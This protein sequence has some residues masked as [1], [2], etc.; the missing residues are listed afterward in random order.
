MPNLSRITIAVVSDPHFCNAKLEGEGSEASHIVIERL[1]ESFGKNPWK[2]L[3]TLV[4]DNNISADFLL[5]PGDITTHAQTKPLEIAWDGLVEL[6]KAMKVS[7]LA[8]ATGNHDVRSRIEEKNTTTIKDLDL[9]HQLFENLKLLSPAYPL[10]L[11]TEK[12]DDSLHRSIRI[13]YF[14]ADFVIHQNEAV[15]LVVFNSC[16]RHITDSDSYERGIIAK[17]TLHELK[18]QLAETSSK[19]INIFLCH[20]HP[21]LHSQDG[22]G[23]YDFMHGGDDLLKILEED[24]DWIVIH[25]HKHEGRLIY[26]PGSTASPVVFSAAS[27]GAVLSSHSLDKYR[28]QFYLLDIE[29]PQLAGPRGVL[30]AWDWHLST[31]WEEAVTGQQGLRSGMGFGE[32]RHPNVLASEIASVVGSSLKKWND[33]ISACPFIRNLTPETLAAVIKALDKQHNLKTTPDPISKTIDQIGPRAN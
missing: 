33:V 21:C 3:L 11:Y 17:S 23:S 28:N 6:G 20:H 13:H 32:R 22:Q 27:I 7:L 10:Q 9:P 19:K 18:Q 12:S 29:L 25:G 30:R 14:G 5:C 15:R 16:A 31:G 8:C 1:S 24:G 26:A 2:D 4:R